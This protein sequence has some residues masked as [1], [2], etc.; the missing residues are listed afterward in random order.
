MLKKIMH[1]QFYRKYRSLILLCLD[2]VIVM[3]SF[4]LAYMLKINFDM[5]EFDNGIKPRLWGV[6]AFVIADFLFFFWVYKIPKSL[7]TYISAKEIFSIVKAVFFACLTLEIFVTLTYREAQILTAVVIAGVIIIVLMLGGRVIYRALR[8]YEY[9]RSGVPGGRLRNALIIGAGDSGYILLKGITKHK[10][11]QAR[12]VG[13]LDD[14]RAGSIVSGIPVLGTIEDLALYVAKLDIGIV[15]IAIP[16]LT[17]SRKRYIIDSLKHFNCEVKVMR[18]SVD[19]VDE[20]EDSITS[21]IK[22][23]SIED[24]LGRGEVELEQD[25]ISEYI[26]GKTVLVTGA[27]G[28]IGGQLS[29]EIFKFHPK[30]LY[31][32]DVNEN[33]LYMLEQDFMRKKRQEKGYDDIAV[34]SEVLSI[35]DYKAMDLFMRETKPDVVY[36]AAAHKHVPLME[37]RPME[38]VKNNVIGTRNLIDISIEHE[39]ERLIMISTDKAV[40]PT[41]AM[42]ATKRMTELLLQSRRNNG[43]TKLAAVRFGNVLGSNG[44]V[45]PIF[46]RQ[47]ETGG[48]VTVTS[49]EIVRYFMTV[50]EAAQLVLQAGYYADK[51]EIFVLDMGEPVRILS[52]AENMISLSGYRP[53]KDIDIIEVGL[54]PGEKMYEELSWSDED[55]EKT[56]NNLIFKN[57]IHYVDKEKLDCVIDELEMMA[58]SDIDRKTM[59]EAIMMGVSVDYSFVTERHS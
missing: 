2:M 18:R 52:L 51:G 9:Q 26:R 33:G 14:A 13:F 35:R 43:K 59:K 36:H 45:I 1:S 55:T 50:P 10:Y 11:Y 56:K 16:S 5:S 47:I 48:P 37:T 19:L 7:W 29:R 39:V 28:T 46:K 40:N 38:A 57:H 20:D 8:E 17:V 30:T 42:G 22:D 34:I 44:S 31:L 4:V 32:L 24:L 12:P 6:T 58:N 15:F 53:Y 21:K 27:G 25:E 41:T 54:R 3:V 23:I 49:K